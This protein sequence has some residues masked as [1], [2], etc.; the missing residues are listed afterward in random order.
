[1]FGLIL[2]LACALRCYGLGFDSLWI[3]EFFAL[4]LSTARGLGEALLPADA[5]VE[6]PPSPT[7]IIPVRKSFE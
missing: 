6:R 3:D 7:T 5:I 4:K 1:M 2:L